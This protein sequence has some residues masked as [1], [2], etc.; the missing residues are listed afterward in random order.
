LASTLYETVPLPLPFDPPVTWIHA[1]DVVA[2]QL[3][4]DCVETLKL[5]DPPLEPK[6]RE[7]GEREYEQDTGGEPRYSLPYP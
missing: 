2:F 6:V 7:V 1:L 3:H 5:P 4:P